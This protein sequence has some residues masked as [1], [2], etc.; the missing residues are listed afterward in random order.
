MDYAIYEYE[1]HL[2][3]IKHLVRMNAIIKIRNR[4][5]RVHDIKLLIDII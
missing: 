4:V 2:Q 3:I 5:K 1:I